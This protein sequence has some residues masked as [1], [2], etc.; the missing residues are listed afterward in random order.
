MLREDCIIERRH[1]KEQI[2]VCDKKRL[3]IPVI[4][5]SILIALSSVVALNGRT[6]ALMLRYLLITI[7]V[8]SSKT[9]AEAKGGGL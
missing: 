4:R 6:L 2:V 1:F 5:N 9:D 7:R 3:V 8:M